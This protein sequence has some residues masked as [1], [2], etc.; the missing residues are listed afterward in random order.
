MEVWEQNMYVLT[1][2][3]IPKE[4]GRSTSTE[5]ML[6]NFVYKSYTHHYLPRVIILLIS[7][8]ASFF[9]A[10]SSTVHLK[11]HPKLD[12]MNNAANICSFYNQ[13]PLITLEYPSCHS[14]AM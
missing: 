3:G 7:F 11:Y 1:N 10:T 13:K 2:A 6:F 12:Q 5:S 8:M 9:P 14:Y 4:K